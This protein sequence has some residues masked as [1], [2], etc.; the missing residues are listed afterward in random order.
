[1]V[2]S[3][4]ELFQPHISSVLSGLSGVVCLMDDVLVF[5]KNQ[6]EHDMKP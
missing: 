6:T 2:T 5:G 4:P 3:A 1:M